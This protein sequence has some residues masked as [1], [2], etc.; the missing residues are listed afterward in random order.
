MAIQKVNKFNLVIFNDDKEKVLNI[1]Q[2]IEEVH[3]I[4]QQ[5]LDNFSSLSLSNI[6]KDIKKIEE[7]ISKLKKYV[8][9]KTSLKELRS[10][11]KEYSYDEIENIFNNFKYLEFID[12]IDKEL[13]FIEN[14]NK[15]IIEL[16]N[17]IKESEEIINI[18]YTNDDKKNL[19]G[20]K[21]TEIKVS[22]LVRDSL[23]KEIENIAVVEEINR[24]S[25]ESILSIAYLNEDEE[26][27]YNILKNNG[28]TQLNLNLS[29]NVIV[30][31]KEYENKIQELEYL[32]SKSI[33][34]LTK[35]NQEIEKLKICLEQLDK[36]KIREEA[37]EKFASTS[38]LYIITAYIT[39]T[40]IKE[41]EKS[42]ANIGAY[43]LVLLEIEDD[44]DAPIKLK[45]NMLIEPFESL[46]KTYALPKYNEVDPTP[47]VAPFYW[48]FF[49]MMVADA[50]YGLVLF[51]ITSLIL[52]LFNL[53]KVLKNSV[54][55]IQ[56]IS[57]SII[58]WGILYGSYFSLDIAVPR[59][60]NPASDYNHIMILSIIFAVIHIFVALAV[61]AYI[62][63]KKGNKIYSIIETAVWYTLLT[64]VLLSL[65]ANKLGFNENIITIIKYIM[66]MSMLLVLIISGR[67]IKGIGAKIGVGLYS[68]YGII[69]YLGDFV[70]YIRLMAIGLSGGFIAQSINMICSMI[71]YKPLTL[72]FVILIFIIGQSINLALAMLS[73]YVHSSRL[74]YVEFFSKFYNGGGEEF[75]D[76][77]TKEKYI[78]IKKDK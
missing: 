67:E 71:G 48:L 66:Y 32:I 59:V 4:K 29:K 6:Q 62:Q 54:K 2:E 12:K 11:K 31:I 17:K 51:L 50:G 60:L 72:I 33:S 22:S 70:S 15:E 47:V 21:V 8:K 39:S 49:G 16:K 14:S 23:I 27:I 43:H 3:F 30:Q 26:E 68:L 52:K 55:F 25:K 34:K 28:F 46:V 76:F 41:L 10:G 75:K 61:K 78:K 56:Y 24:N 44:E 38:N 58:F 64:T 9:T 1:L 20:F 19:K 77:K 7:T 13:L 42:L 40:R 69:G 35:L 36:L 18:D 45:N 5:E 63:Y 74:I 57:I 53:D 65:S 73:A 37:S